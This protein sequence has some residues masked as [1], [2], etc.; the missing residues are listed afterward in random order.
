M[1][2][3]LCETYHILK[4]GHLPYLDDVPFLLNQKL[5]FN[6]FVIFTTKPPPGAI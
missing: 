5:N 1:Q 3:Y 6:Y 2:I 4:K